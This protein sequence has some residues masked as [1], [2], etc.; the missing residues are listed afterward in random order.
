M[1]PRSKLSDLSTDDNTEF[2]VDY[3]DEPADKWRRTGGSDEAI[4]REH[5]H[6]VPTLYLFEGRRFVS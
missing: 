1:N 2:Y 4:R 3:S 6:V 5:L